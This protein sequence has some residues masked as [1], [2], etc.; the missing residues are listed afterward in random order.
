MVRWKPGKKRIAAR[1]QKQSDCHMQ[2]RKPREKN[3]ISVLGPPNPKNP[4]TPS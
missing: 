3:V 2:K 1:S 4:K